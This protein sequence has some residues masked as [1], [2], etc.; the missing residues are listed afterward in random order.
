MIYFF[1][2]F[3]I[4]PRFL[5][6]LA[7]RLSEASHLH[8]VDDCYWDVRLCESGRGNVLEATGGFYD[9]EADAVR[10]LLDPFSERIGVSSR[11][12]SD[13]IRQS[14]TAIHHLLEPVTRVGGDLAMVA[15]GGRDIA[16]A[17]VY[18]WSGFGR[19]YQRVV[20]AAAT[21]LVRHDIANH[22]IWAGGDSAMRH[23]RDSRPRREPR[24][25]M[26][27]LTIAPVT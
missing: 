26:W 1:L 27:E 19:F 22:N 25:L 13:N 20:S 5:V 8:G 21:T 17:R 10:Q 15:A 6:L 3:V 4:S 24:R 9:G 12:D 16:Q 18:F 7:E 11:F 14:W 2:F 23:I